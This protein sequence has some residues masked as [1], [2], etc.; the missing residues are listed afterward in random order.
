MKKLSLA[1]LLFFGIFGT[2]CSQAPKEPSFDEANFLEKINPKQCDVEH[3]DVSFDHDSNSALT[4]KPKGPVFDLSMI[5][6]SI[7][8]ALLELSTMAG[9]AIVADE[10]VTGQ[11][12]ANIEGKTVEEI[13]DIICHSGPFDFKKIDDYYYVGVLD[14]T[15]PSW[16]KLQQTHNYKTRYLAPSELVNSLAP[17]Q[18]KLVSPDDSKR[19]VTITAPASLSKQILSTVRS[20]DR[21]KRQIA[22]ALTITEVNNNASKRIGKILN[23]G[24]A[25][26]YTGN[27]TPGYINTTSV[28]TSHAYEFFLHSIQALEKTGDAKIKANPVLV[29]VEGK[30][31][32]FASTERQL[33]VDPRGY[34]GSKMNFLEAGTSLQITPFLTGDQRILLQIKD[35]SASHLDKDTNN[36]QEHKINTSIIVNAGE[37]VVFGGFKRNNSIF[38]VTKVPLLG[39]LPVIGFFF[40]SKKKINQE[41]EILFSVRPELLCGSS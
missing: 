33:L 1:T 29:T 37:T 5:E 15:S 39:D 32:K 23:Y 40:K 31:A 12:S 9:V 3:Q 20:I 11:V 7:K 25:R 21:P 38:E 10:N 2:A 16:W 34:I 13:L 28:I 8:E 30:E 22:L 18:Q 4:R 24:T 36:I 6:S 41:K 35:S 26:D 19:M 14:P 27:P 17:D